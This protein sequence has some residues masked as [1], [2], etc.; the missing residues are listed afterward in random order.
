MT[1]EMQKIVEKISELEASRKKWQ[2]KA[3]E[4]ILTLIRKNGIQQL[5][6]NKKRLFDFYA[7]IISR[8][9]QRSLNAYIKKNGL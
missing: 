5:K 9:T 8:K 4:F 6:M 3:D 7:A 1:E 2:K